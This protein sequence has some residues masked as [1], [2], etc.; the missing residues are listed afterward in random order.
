[1]LPAVQSPPECSGTAR[2]TETLLQSEGILPRG[3]QLCHRRQG[4]ISATTQRWS[5]SGGCSW[6]ARRT[7][8]FER[9]QGT[10]HKQQ[11]ATERGAPGQTLPED[12]ALCKTS[13]IKQGLGYLTDTQLYLT[14]RVCNSVSSEIL[15]SVFHALGIFQ[16]CRFTLL[17][18]TGEAF[19]LCLY[20][21]S[22]VLQLTRGA[23]L[24]FN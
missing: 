1:M 24:S 7:A 20:L 6:L 2:S 5:C 3:R 17:H 13:K 10:K 19:S 16:V 23:A 14:S 12:S 9:A 11:L 8:V 4:L 18:F 21:K 15:I 22:P